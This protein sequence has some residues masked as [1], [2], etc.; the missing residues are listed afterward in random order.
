MKTAVGL[1]RV[2]VV[3]AGEGA[4]R[5]LRALRELVRTGHA[6]AVI[7]FHDSGTG[8]LRPVREADEVFDLRGPI[9]EALRAARADSAWLGAAPLP[10]RA[11]FAEACERAGVMHIGPPAEA[12]RRLAGAAGLADFASRLGVRATTFRDAAPQA[13]LI[14]AI[15]ARDRDGTARVLG[16]GDASL[17][18]GDVAVLTESPPPGLTPGEDGAVRDLAERACAAADWVGVCALQQAFD[19]GTRQWALLGIDER[20]RDGVRV[21]FRKRR[22]KGKG[23]TD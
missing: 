6:D 19:P 7:A 15:V 2:A 12:L 11:Q 21:V 20:F 16:L 17:R 13:R 22:A 8:P 10:Q 18:R 14:E 4:P 23:A 5:V 1:G 9:D 3:G